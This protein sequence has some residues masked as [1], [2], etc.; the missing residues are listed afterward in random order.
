MTYQFDNETVG[1][2]A[3][4]NYGAKMGKGYLQL[5]EFDLIA[6]AHDIACYWSI[7]SAFAAQQEYGSNIGDIAKE[8][9]FSE[10]TAEI[11]SNGFCSIEESSSI[12]PAVQL[13]CSTAI[14]ESSV[15]PTDYLQMFKRKLNEG[16][17][18]YLSENTSDTS[19]QT[20]GRYKRRDIPA[21]D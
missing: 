3:A 14:L 4:G 1:P 8:A 18:F 7:Y 6:E 15:V 19:E 10:L 17:S 9:S 11:N 5:D 13:Q 2:D 16:S 12:P 20:S 21:D